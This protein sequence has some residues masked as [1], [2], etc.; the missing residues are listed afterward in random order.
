MFAVV[1]I[2]V[3]FSL[4]LRQFISYPAFQLSLPRQSVVQLPLYLSL[5][6]SNKPSL[7]F[8][9]LCLMNRLAVS[10]SLFFRF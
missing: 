5:M 1:A 4:S 3:Q 9:G 7:T 10:T 6:P 2:M 8:S